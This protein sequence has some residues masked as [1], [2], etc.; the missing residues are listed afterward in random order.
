MRCFKWYYAG[1]FLGVAAFLVGLVNNPN[2]I[3]ST[4]KTETLASLAP[5]KSICDQ[6]FKITKTKDLKKLFEDNNYSIHDVDAR[7][8]NR[9]PR[10]YCLTVPR[11]IRNVTCIQEKKKLFIAMMLPMILK[12]NEDIMIERQKIMALRAIQDTGQNLSDEDK[13]WLDS[14]CVKYKLKSLDIETLLERVD[15]IPPSIALAQSAIESGWGTSYAALSKNSTFGM[16][17]KLKV[18]SYEDLWE[19]T[20]HYARNLNSNAAYKKFRK[21]RAHMR[22]NNKRWNLNQL[23]DSLISYCEYGKRYTQKVIKAI[24]YNKFQQFDMAK[25]HGTEEVILSY[26]KNM[27]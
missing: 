2:H 21:N 16:T 25:L 6:K 11:D 8:S 18:K 9:I 1:G 12:I 24:H 7:H 19:S 15:I 27:S 5:P 10:L 23:V 13:E 22:L 20:Y 26:N 14:L 3:K 17:I 4:M